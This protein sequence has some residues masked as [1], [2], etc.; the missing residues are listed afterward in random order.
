MKKTNLKNQLFVYLTK[1]TKDW[2]FDAF[3]ALHIPSGISYWTGNGLMLFSNNSTSC[4]VGIGLFNKV[5]LWFWIK[6]AQREKVLK[7]ES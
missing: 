5:K 2:R 7:N 6:D 3:N 4:K 1:S